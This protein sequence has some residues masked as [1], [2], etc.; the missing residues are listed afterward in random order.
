MDDV[1]YDVLL[2]MWE[3]RLE[4]ICAVLSQ[5]D[6]I[7]DVWIGHLCRIVQWRLNEVKLYKREHACEQD[8]LE[9]ES[10]LMIRIGED[11]EDILNDTEEVQLVESVGNRLFGAGEVVDNF[12]AYQTDG[13][14]I[15]NEY[16]QGWIVAYSSI[17]YLQYPAWYA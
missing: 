16:K 7:R 15:R 11:E 1:R 12:Q 9:F 3:C 14:I 2:D 10:A 6:R 4:Q 13:Q 5:E 8:T 17:Q